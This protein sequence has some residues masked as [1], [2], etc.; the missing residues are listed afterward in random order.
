MSQTDTQIRLFGKPEVAG[1]RR[2]AVTLARG[3]NV[4]DAR[5]KARKSAELLEAKL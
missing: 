3:G 4:D 5:E 2:M 1:K